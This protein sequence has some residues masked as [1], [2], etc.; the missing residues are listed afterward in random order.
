MGAHAGLAARE[1]HIIIL[2][3]LPATFRTFRLLVQ[4]IA[5]AAG[6]LLFGTQPRQRHQNFPFRAFQIRNFELS[7]HQIHPY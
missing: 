3:I 7:M 5:L 4:S 6:H 1:I 2:E